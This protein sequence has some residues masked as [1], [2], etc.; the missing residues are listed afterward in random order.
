MNVGKRVAH[1]LVELTVYLA[2]G[3]VVAVVLVKAALPALHQG[4]RLLASL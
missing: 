2:V 3:S 4:V 1:G